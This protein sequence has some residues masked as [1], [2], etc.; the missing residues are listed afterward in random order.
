MSRKN[1]HWDRSRE[2]I[3]VPT[4]RRP[5]HDGTSIAAA[6]VAEEVIEEKHVASPVAEEAA[7]EKHVA[8]SVVAVS[9]PSTRRVSYTL[10]LKRGQRHEL[11]ALRARGRPNGPW[12]PS[13]ETIPDDEGLTVALQFLSTIRL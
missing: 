9:A 1:Q 3:V 6:S 5:E 13:L 10:Q 7:E 11:M 12:S 2:L 4:L 8:A